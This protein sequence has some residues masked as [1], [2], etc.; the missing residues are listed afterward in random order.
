MWAPV[1]QPQLQHTRPLSL[2]KWATLGDFEPVSLL[3]FPSSSLLSHPRHS[4]RFSDLPVTLHR[5][6]KD[7][8]TYHRPCLI[9]TSHPHLSPLSS[10]PVLHTSTFPPHPLSYTSSDTPEHR[11][12]WIYRSS[13]D[14]PRI[15]PSSHRHPSLGLSLLPFPCFSCFT[16]S[17][18]YL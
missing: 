3:R 6:P 12:P 9:L 15:S 11:T 17:C 10:Y 14:L 8:S 5:T 2:S 16:L 18:F 4:H 7:P 1:V 13:L